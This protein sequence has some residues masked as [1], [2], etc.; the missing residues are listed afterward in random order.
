MGSTRFSRL[1]ERSPGVS[2]V[3]DP[4]H[5]SPQ[6]RRRLVATG[7]E[8]HESLL[9]RIRQPLLQS[10]FDQTHVPIVTRLFTSLRFSVSWQVLGSDNR[11]DRS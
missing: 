8:E 2:R 5:V 9:L 3:E 10:I 6:H 11:H 4:S 7:A 1:D